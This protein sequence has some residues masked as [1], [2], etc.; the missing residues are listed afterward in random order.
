M[1]E[2]LEFIFSSVWRFIG[3]LL[4]LATACTWSP[5]TINKKIGISEKKKSKNEK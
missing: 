5:I 4:L 1:I 3:F 2:L